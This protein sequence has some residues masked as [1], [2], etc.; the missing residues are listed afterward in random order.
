MAG[1]TQCRRT[2]GAGEDA[3]PASAV[4]VKADCCDAFPLGQVLG[5]TS[6][7]LNPASVGA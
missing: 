7:R 6:H 3:A 1:K 4:L 2:G 5:Y